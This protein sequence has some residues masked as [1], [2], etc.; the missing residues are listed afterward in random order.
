MISTCM[1]TEKCEFD[2]EKDEERVFFSKGK[3]K[4]ENR[5]DNNGKN[6]RNCY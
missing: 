2:D 5:G 1:A 3:S 4:S 6:G